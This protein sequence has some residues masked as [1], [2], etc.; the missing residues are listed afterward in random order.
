MSLGSFGMPPISLARNTIR[1]W[2]RVNRVEL[3]SKIPLALV[4]GVDDTCACIREAGS[5]QLV[6]GQARRG[7][8]PCGMPPRGAEGLE[9]S[10]F[11][12]P[13]PNPQ[14]R[15]AT[16]NGPFMPRGLVDEAF[17]FRAAVPS[18][19]RASSECSVRAVW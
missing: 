12:G 13:D 15:W 5:I 7:G 9:K 8:D 3:S 2:W 6:C 14:L 17:H 1:A 19:R 4:E 10:H 16:R 18:L 11:L